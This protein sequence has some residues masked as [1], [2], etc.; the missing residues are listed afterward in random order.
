MKRAYS[1]AFRFVNDHHLAEEI[2]QDAFIRAYESIALFRGDSGFATWLH[3]IIVNTALNTIKKNKRRLE[4]ELTGNL[5]LDDAGS[6]PLHGD[7]ALLPRQIRNALLQLPDM[8]R[9]TVILRHLEGYSTQE[10]SRILGCSQGT[11][12]V[13]LFRG[14]RKLRDSLRF[15]KED[16]HDI[17]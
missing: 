14:L 9:T 8:Q 15:L 6:S 16:H 17:A 3:R 1:L 7:Q 12:K 4:H 13:H 2:A 5:H 10:V 11:V